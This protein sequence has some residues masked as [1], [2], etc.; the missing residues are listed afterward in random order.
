MVNKEPGIPYVLDLF[1]EEIINCVTEAVSR[2]MPARTATEAL[3]LTLTVPQFCK[4][5]NVSKSVAYEMI[6]SEGFPAFRVGTKYLINTKGL[7]MWIDRQSKQGE[8]RMNA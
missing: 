1:K 7:Q 3:P 4:Q 8:W 5:M 2:L 6:N